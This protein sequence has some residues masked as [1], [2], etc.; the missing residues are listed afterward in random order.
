M[1]AL[2]TQERHTAEED[3]CTALCQVDPPPPHLLLFPVPTYHSLRQAGVWRPKH[4]HPPA[5]LLTRQLSGRA[6][7]ELGC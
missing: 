2:E 1:S 4:L 6:A 3:P 7:S 5:L